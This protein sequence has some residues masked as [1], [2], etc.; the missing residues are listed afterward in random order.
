[1]GWPAVLGMGICALGIAVGGFLVGASR[2][3]FRRCRTC[4]RYGQLAGSEG[5]AQ[6]GGCWRTQA[7]DFAVSQWTM[8]QFMDTPPSILVETAKAFAFADFR[9]V[10]PELRVPTLVIQ[11]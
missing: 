4:G 5:F 3:G 2:L 6:C 7:L 8:Q 10:L 1:M 11:G 9:T